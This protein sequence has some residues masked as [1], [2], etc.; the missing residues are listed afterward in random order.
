MAANYI[1]L[2]TLVLNLWLMSTPP[3]QWKHTDCQQL[4]VFQSPCTDCQLPWVSSHPAATN[5]YRSIKV[6]KIS[7]KYSGFLENEQHVKQWLPHSA[8]DR[9]K[10]TH[11]SQDHKD[12]SI[13]NSQQAVMAT[14]NMGLLLSRELVIITATCYRPKKQ[15]AHCATNHIQHNT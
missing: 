11:V 12:D 13:I 15:L 4:L 2:Y 6:K 8:S 9:M 10:C 14:S 3:I 7:C 5:I 1:V